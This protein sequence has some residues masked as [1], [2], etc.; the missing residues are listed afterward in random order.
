MVDTKRK[1]I[2]NNNNL[3][4]NNCPRDRHMFLET[5]GEVKKQQEQIHHVKI[6]ESEKMCGIIHT[7]GMI[8]QGMVVAR[9][10]NSMKEKVVGGRTPKQP[11]DTVQNQRVFGCIFVSDGSNSSAAEVNNNFFI[12]KWWTTIYQSKNKA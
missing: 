4:Q 6:L 7:R 8:C 2:K 5:C 3:G 11:L 10:I 12:L 1:K 9:N